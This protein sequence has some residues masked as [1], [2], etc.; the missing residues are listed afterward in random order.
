M[1]DK[2]D[3]PELTDTQWRVMEVLASEHLAAELDPRELGGIA[4]EAMARR[5][6]LTNEEVGEAV[7]GLIDLNFISQGLRIRE[8]D[9]SGYRQVQCDFQWPDGQYSLSGFCSLE[10]ANAVGRPMLATAQKMVAAAWHTANSGQGCPCGHGN[11]VFDFILLKKLV[12]AYPDPITVEAAHTDIM[13][14]PD[15]IC[16][17]ARKVLDGLYRAYFAEL[18]LT[19]TEL[20]DR[21]TMPEER[22]REHTK[23]LIEAGLWSDDEE[24]DR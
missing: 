6:G 17:D 24:D 20:A 10:H 2:P 4:N 21:L 8:A 18:N 14:V 9:E 3:K 23:T 5:L 19:P 15:H 13:P 7:Q 12:E 16:A 22:V 1:T 11:P